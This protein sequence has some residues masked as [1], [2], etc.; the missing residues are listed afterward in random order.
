MPI[1]SLTGRI[2]LAVTKNVTGTYYVPAPPVSLSLGFAHPEKVFTR[3]VT[4]ESKER[5]SASLVR[6]RTRHAVK[7]R[8]TIIKTDGVHCIISGVYSIDFITITQ[9]SLVP[10]AASSTWLYEDMPPIDLPIDNSQTSTPTN[11]ALC[12][13][14]LPSRISRSSCRR[15]STLPGPDTTL[16]WCHTHVRRGEISQISRLDYPARMI[17]GPTELEAW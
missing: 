14:A 1:L 3:R 4:R 5:Y 17:C 6:S 13:A 8:P 16:A 10:T 7:H 2:T 12:R 11:D 15:L 9:T